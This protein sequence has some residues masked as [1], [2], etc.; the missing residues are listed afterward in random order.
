MIA[1]IVAVRGYNYRAKTGEQKT[2]N[3]IYITSV[4]PL[5]EDSYDG[6]YRYGCFIEEVRIPDRLHLTSEDLKELCF[7]KVELILERPIGMRFE[8]LVSLKPI[9]DEKD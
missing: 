8:Q 9:D 2:G 3:L 7:H 5:D 6:N 4:E 1:K